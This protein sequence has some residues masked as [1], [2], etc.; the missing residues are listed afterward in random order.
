MVDK[1]NASVIQGLIRHLQGKITLHASAVEVAG[2]AVALVG[3]SGAGKSTLA[4]AICAEN[5]ACLVGDD[6]VAIELP[7]HGVDLP[8]T[9]VPSQR[10]AWLLPDSR[11]AL[12]II[13]SSPGKAS[14]E[15]AVAPTT[16]SLM[17]IVGLRF[18]ESATKPT[19]KRVRGQ[20]AF[21]LLANATIRFVLDEPAAQVREFDQLQSLVE[22]C[23]VFE[24]S[25][26]RDLGKLRLSTDI[27]H[28]LALL[29]DVLDREP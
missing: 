14:V 26:P 6:T 27:V 29:P 22:R 11:V 2:R 1:L 5:G 13:S 4:A 8:V 9:V 20:Q 21:S 12:G 24:L 18:D 15:L 25:R 23:P 10:M 17:A 3:A 16:P 28:R 7:E 19:L